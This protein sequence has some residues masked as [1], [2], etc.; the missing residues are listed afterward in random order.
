[1][2]DDERIRRFAAPAVAP[3]WIGIHDDVRDRCLLGADIAHVR[4]DVGVFIDA[5]RGYHVCGSRNLKP[6]ASAPPHEN[7]PNENDR[8][9]NRGLNCDG[10]S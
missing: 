2:F 4:D 8:R 6:R 9:N 7:L 5:R 3:I 10:S 1:M